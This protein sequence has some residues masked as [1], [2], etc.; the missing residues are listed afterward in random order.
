MIAK[1]MSIFARHGIPEEF[2]S[3]NGPQLSA[4]QF[5]SFTRMHDIKHTISSPYYP[6]ANGMAERAVRTAKSILK[7]PDPY[8][9]LLCY[10][11]TPTEPTNESPARLLMGRRLRT[12]VPKLNCQLRPEWPNLVTVRQNDAKAKQA[13]EHT[14]NK[15]Y[16]AEPLPAL[17]VGD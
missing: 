10:R 12:T 15:R 3:D 2:V 7:Q 14:Y 5:K 6:Q 1:L 16:S 17:E 11:D 13:Y 8:L 9:A 4:D